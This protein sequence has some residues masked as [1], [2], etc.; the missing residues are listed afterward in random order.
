MIKEYQTVREIKGPLVFVEGVS[1]VGYGELVRIKDETDL[2]GQVIE[3]S[4]GLAVVQVLGNTIGLSEKARVRF[5]GDVLR[6][7]V[8]SKMLGRVFNG[9]GHPIDGGL[10]P[11][12]EEKIDVRGN[13]LN[14]VSRD[15]PSNFVQTGI[16]T[17]DVM[18]SLVRGQKLPIFSGSGLL[19]YKLA[20]QIARQAKVKDEDFGVVFGAMGITAEE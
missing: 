6:L 14:P 1:G 20:A 17:L 5:S 8:G 4:E 18:G 9:M 10:A 12:F 16:S 19:H 11:N 15:V 2:I 3:V 13:A 7:G